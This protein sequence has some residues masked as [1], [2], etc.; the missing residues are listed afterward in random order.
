TLRLL[1]KH[2]LRRKCE[3]QFLHHRL[4]LLNQQCHTELRQNLWQ[5]YLNLGSE[6]EVWP[7]VVM[8]MAKTDEHLV[9]Q[10]FVQ[11][12]LNE[13]KIKY[14]QFINELS[15]QL[16]SCPVTLMELQ[17]SLD[18]HLKE[19]VQIQQK[20]IAT[21]MQFQLK[22]YEDMITEIELLQTL[23]SFPLSSDQVN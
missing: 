13:M 20:Y 22:R 8:K 4:Q 18:Q 5:S 21:K 19:F 12:H 7:N 9:C 6:K 11:K 1:L 10:Q 23:S 3:R 14:D 16:Q 17:S 2:K 15:L